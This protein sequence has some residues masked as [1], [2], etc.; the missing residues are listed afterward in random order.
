MDGNAVLEHLFPVNPI[1]ELA[2]EIDVRGEELVGIEPDF[3]IAR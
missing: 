2:V 3:T 1:A